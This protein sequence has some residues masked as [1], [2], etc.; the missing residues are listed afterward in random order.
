[1][2]WVPSVLLVGHGSVVGVKTGYV[3]DGSGIESR[4][5]RDSAPVRAGHGRQQ[6]CKMDTESL[7]GRTAAGAWR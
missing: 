6:A 7:Y 1:M 2:I 5:W 4:R 3:L